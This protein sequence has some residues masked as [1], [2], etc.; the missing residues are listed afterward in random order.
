MSRHIKSC[1]FSV[2]VALT[3]LTN[4]TLTIAGEEILKNPGFNDD[5]DQNG[6]SR[7][8]VHDERSRPLA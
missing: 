8:L 7:S 6:S 2:F 4:C 5:A 3:L 1:T